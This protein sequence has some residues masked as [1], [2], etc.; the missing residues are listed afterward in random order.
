[1]VAVSVEGADS[2]YHIRVEVRY[3]IGDSMQTFEWEAEQYAQL[4]NRMSEI[5]GELAEHVIKPEKKKSKTWLWV[6]VVEE[7]VVEGAGD[8]LRLVAE[9]VP[10]HSL[11]QTCPNLHR[12]HHLR[13][14]QRIYLFQG[15]CHVCV[16]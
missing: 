9:Q 2:K 12:V 7:A 10:R 11:R 15:G 6:P 4:M 1:M 5:A 8:S 3:S 16:A 13:G 14:V